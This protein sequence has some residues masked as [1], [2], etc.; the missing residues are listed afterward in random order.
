MKQGNQ[1]YLFLNVKQDYDSREM[2]E[3]Y[4]IVWTVD[5]NNNSPRVTRKLKKYLEL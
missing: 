1:I 2:L 3:Q 4:D 5:P